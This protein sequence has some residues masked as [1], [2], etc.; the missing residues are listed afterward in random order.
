MRV[1]LNR[2]NIYVALSVIMYLQ[3]VSENYKLAYI[4]TKCG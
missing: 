2:S 1:W 3:Y 4:F